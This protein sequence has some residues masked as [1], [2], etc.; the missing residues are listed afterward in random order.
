MVNSHIDIKLITST[1]QFQDRFFQYKTNEN[2]NKR[3]VLANMESTFLKQ[4]R[5]NMTQECA[6]KPKLRFSIYS[7]S[8]RNLQSI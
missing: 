6:E 2:F 5:Q 7:K 1:V 3:D 4:Q 8:L